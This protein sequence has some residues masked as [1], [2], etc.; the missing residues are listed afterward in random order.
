MSTTDPHTTDERTFFH[1]SLY[2]AMTFSGAISAGVPGPLRRRRARYHP[3]TPRNPRPGAVPLPPPGHNRRCAPVGL[4][5]RGAYGDVTSSYTTFSPIMRLQGQ[6][7]GYF[8]AW[9]SAF[10]S[11]R[12]FP[13]VPLLPGISSWASSLQRD[14]RRRASLQPQCCPVYRVVP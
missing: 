1:A 9:G 11:Y 3:P 2:I 7:P 13:S 14:I 8:P 12:I 4:H 6:I 10:A 5:A